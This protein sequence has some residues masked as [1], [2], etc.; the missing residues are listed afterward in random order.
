MARHLG[1]RAVAGLRRQILLPDERI[2]WYWIARQAR[3]R[4]QEAG[5]F[6]LVFSSSRPET[7]HVVGAYYSKQLRLPW[8]ADFRDL[9]TAHDVPRRLPPLRQFEK[10]IERHVLRRSSAL[11][12]VSEPLAE[13]LRRFHRKPTYV[14]TNGF[15]EDDFE[16]PVN[17]SKGL[18]P[19]QILY[20]GT[21]F[22]GKQRPEILF[23]A[24]AR[25]LASDL[26]E[27]D[28]LRV[29]FLGPK[30]ESVVETAARF[31]LRG[32][33]RAEG[34]VPFHDALRRQQ[35]ADVLLLLEWGGDGR[36][37]VLTGKLFSYFG[38]RRPVL[39]IGPLG[40]GV[41]EILRDTRAG[42]HAEDAAGV[43]TLLTRFVRDLH[44]KGA[45]PYEANEPLLRARYSWRALAGRWST[46]F[47]EIVAR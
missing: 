7:S 3:S 18:R 26:I 16:P 38:S 4:V 37:G 35:E 8:V 17:D 10:V 43:V 6:D 25:A 30:C 44:V 15:D 27:R 41:D 9:W 23:E 42:V 2:G 5:G 40:T 11:A 45:V 39:A 46:V 13:K 29:T 28:D 19:L 14:I 36:A 32:V 1:S 33:V 24:I 12:T 47:Q 21:V 31:G 34:S 20:S 22:P